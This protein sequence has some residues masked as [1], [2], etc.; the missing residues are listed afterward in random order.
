MAQ[1]QLQSQLQDMQRL[2]QEREAGLNAGDI[3]RDVLQGNRER[4]QSVDPGTWYRSGNVD[5][6]TNWYDYYIDPEA[7]DYSSR[8]IRGLMSGPTSTYNA[9]KSVST[10]TNNPLT[11]WYKDGFWHVLAN[12]TDGSGYLTDE[13]RDNVAQSDT[14]KI[15]SQMN[16]INIAMQEAEA[17]GD[18]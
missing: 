12:P 5:D 10:L 16:N 8:V 7:D 9:V 14:T 2:Q 17:A 4:T 11:R 1:Q 15:K 13:A 6:P 18:G 3:R